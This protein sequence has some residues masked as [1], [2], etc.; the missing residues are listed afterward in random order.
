MVTSSWTVSMITHHLGKE[1]YNIWSHWQAIHTTFTH[2]TNLQL[3][4]IHTSWTG[5]SF[6][7]YWLVAHYSP[8]TTSSQPLDPV[9]YYIQRDWC[10]LILRRNESQQ[11]QR[12]PM[13]T[14][15]NILQL[16]AFGGVVHST[17][18]CSLQLER[19]GHL[20]GFDGGADGHKENMC[21]TVLTS[22]I[23]SWSLTN[24][25][26]AIHWSNIF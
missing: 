9:G 16:T 8:M 21:V 7:R 20:L 19:G 6:T 15:L 13:F 26:S 10:H 11:W 22:C 12:R 1:A 23:F 5:L 17:A 3:M 24:I 14:E 4:R 18:S 25:I 2:K